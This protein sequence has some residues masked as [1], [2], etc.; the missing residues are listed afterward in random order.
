M[1]KF[2]RKRIGVYSVLELATP[3]LK[4]IGLFRLLITATE[5]QKIRR[6]KHFNL[7]VPTFGLGFR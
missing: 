4:K 5:L 2:Y 1:T 3:V 6:I 7:N